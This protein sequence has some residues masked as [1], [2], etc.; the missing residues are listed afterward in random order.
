ME[1]VERVA[2][3]PAPRPRQLAWVDVLRQL[4]AQLEQGTVY[5]RHLVAIAT[6]LDDVMRA[7][8]RRSRT[9]LHSSRWPLG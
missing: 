3:V 7:M 4:A 5:D 1:I 2:P 6:A 8:H 9:G